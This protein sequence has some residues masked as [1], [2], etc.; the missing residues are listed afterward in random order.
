MFPYCRKVSFTVGQVE[1]VDE[2]ADVQGTKM[3]ELV[4][5]VLG[6]VELELK[7]MTF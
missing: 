7:R 6:A 2:V 4:N 3:L 1:K 5:G